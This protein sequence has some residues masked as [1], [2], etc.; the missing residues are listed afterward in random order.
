MNKPKIGRPKKTGEKKV[1]QSVSILPSK[2]KKVEKRFE[3]LTAYVHAKLL[4]D[5][6]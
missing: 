6:I 1:Q 2:L 3:S 5:N 4:Q